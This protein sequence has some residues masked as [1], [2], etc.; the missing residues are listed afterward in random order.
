[1]V[2]VLDILPMADIADFCQRWKI[3]ELAV[4]GSVLRAD[5]SPESDVDVM[6]TFEDDSDWSLL[7]H[8]RMEQELQ[9]L[10]QR[11][12]DLVTRRAV[13]NSENWVRRKDILRTATVLFPRNEVAHGTR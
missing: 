11:D 6:V 1:M 4:F 5:F 9:D 12:V 3:R 7:D 10:L 13:E 8:I 2:N